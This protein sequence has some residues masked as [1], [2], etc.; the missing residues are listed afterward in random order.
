MSTLEPQEPQ[1]PQ[2]P[3][4]AE[5]TD[6]GVPAIE[7]PD[8]DFDEREAFFSNGGV[9]AVK[10]EGPSVGEARID[11]YTL[12]QIYTQLDRVQRGLQAEQAGIALATRG[13]IP[14][15]EGAAAWRAKA[16][17]GGSFVLLFELG[18]PESLSMT[19]AGS[20]DSP[21]IASIRRLLGLLEL[22][23]P[24]LVE[25]LTGMADRLGRDLSALVKVLADENL[26]STWRSRE[27]RDP[28][29]MSAK[30]SR[31]RHEAIETEVLSQ[32]VIE[33]VRGL[34]FRVDTKA[35]K[36]KLDPDDGG[37]PVTAE[38]DLEQLEDLRAGLRRRVHVE[39]TLR[40]F[41]YAYSREP[42]KRDRQLLRVVE[43]L[44]G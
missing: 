33:S 6:E 26:R 43:I 35:G 32:P 1:E 5:R 14:L 2:E 41:R 30:Q 39:L 3:E 23:P 29:L 16:P 20:L 18:E 21:T 38:F 28:V 8:G 22:D 40:E 27:D 11:T 31:E 42:F 12:G 34:L 4:E 44:E 9:L 17:V 7:P 25:E 36:I 15:A 37:D 13:R 19:E 24:L 10:L